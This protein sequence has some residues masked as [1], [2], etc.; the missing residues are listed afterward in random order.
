MNCRIFSF[1]A[2]Y[3]PEDSARESDLLCSQVN[4]NCLKLRLFD[5]LELALHP[6]I[7][8]PDQ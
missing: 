1:A 3:D 5:T 6:V 4:M 7:H 8:L 2:I